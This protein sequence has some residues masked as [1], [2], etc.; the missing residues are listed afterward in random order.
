[1]TLRVIPEGLVAASAAVDAITA[2]LAAAHA[3]AAPV[4]SVVV[5]PAADPVSLAAAA[6]FS[7]RGSQHSAAAAKGVEV[8]GRAGLGVS[9]AGVNYVAGDAAAASTY[10]GAS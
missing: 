10:L 6:V 5:P 3:A 9:L 2:Q 7:E 4:V 8:L 1:M